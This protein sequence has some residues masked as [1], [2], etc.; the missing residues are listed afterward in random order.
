MKWFAF[1]DALK[2]VAAQRNYEKCIRSTAISLPHPPIA[3]LFNHFACCIFSFLIDLMKCSNICISVYRR[4]IASK[5]DVS[6]LIVFFGGAFIWIFEFVQSNSVNRFSLLIKAK[7]MIAF[8]VNYYQFYFI[9]K[10]LQIHQWNLWIHLSSSLAFAIAF[11]FNVDAVNWNI[12][13]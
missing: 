5:C 3:Y 8:D 1:A 7:S 11:A 13:V 2:S 6:M 9:M 12:Q 4:S 10:V